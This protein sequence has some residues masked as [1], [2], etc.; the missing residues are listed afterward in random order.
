MI[1]WRTACAAAGYTCNAVMVDTTEAEVLSVIAGCGYARPYQADM[2]GVVRDYDRSAE[3]PVQLF[4]PRNTAGFQW[5]KAF[6]AL[7][8]GLRVTFDDVAQDYQPR[9]IIIWRRGVKQG[10][11]LLEQVRYEGVTTEADATARAHYDL[12]QLRRRATL[13][14]FEAGWD[15][16]ASRRGDLVALVHDAVAVNSGFM[17]VLEGGTDTVRIEAPVTTS[18]EPDIWSVDDVWSVSDVWKLGQRTQCV[19]RRPDGTIQ[20]V[21]LTNATGQ[22]DVLEFAETVDYVPPESLIATHV[23]DTEYRRML[24]LNIKRKSDHTASITLV[25]E[26]NEVFA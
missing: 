20:T 11:G 9:Q 13:F 24:V 16:L 1:E 10:G 17:R 25:D 14:T 12:A 2:W 23:L 18:N 6:K 4:T 15:T 7:P 21:A 8:D 19:I 3:A 26:A 5:T 22:S